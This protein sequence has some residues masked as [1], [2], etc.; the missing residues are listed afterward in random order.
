MNSL[1]RINQFAWWA[2]GI[3][4]LSLILLA[5]AL[6]GCGPAKQDAKG[7]GKDGAPVF[8][9]PARPVQTS[10]AQM[11]GLERTIAAVG[12]LAAYEQATLGVKVSGRMQLVSVDIGSPVKKGQLIAQL[13]KREYEVKLMQAE[14]LLAQ[15]RAKL[16]LPLGGDDD[17]V[18]A[19]Q[20]SIV[21]EAA[22]VLEEA[23]K[24]RE[25]VL[26]LSK[27]GVSSQ[28]ELETV[29][30]AYEVA[31]NRQRDA[32]EEVRNRQALLAQRR[33]EV[34]IAKQQLEETTIKAPFDGLVQDRRASQGEYLSVGAP[35]ATVV[36][37]DILRLRLDIPERRASLVKEGHP[38]RLTVTGD[39]NLYLGEIKR[40]SP[41]LSDLN[42]MLLVEA[43]VPNPGRLRPG[44]FAQADI[45]VSK[46]EP[47]LTVPLDALVTFAG[48]EKVVTIKEG[49]AQERPV[50]SG[51]RGANW[52]EILTGLK[53]GE[54]VVRNP[55][56]LRT[57]EPV[58]V[59]AGKES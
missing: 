11:Q 18:E 55:G 34:A 20:T 30:A 38:V 12:A 6:T 13:E 57:G 36:R 9:G 7:K 17:T 48:V 47:A 21:R 49:K 16:G 35:V 26:K 10:K 33:A 8:T 56:N 3:T 14:A 52:V 54:A 58:V 28:S 5:V 44:F 41:M 42:R 32:M 43:D 40:L 22:A 59:K 39:T 51:R 50:S 31:V 15:A 29:E 25:R 2:A 23:K 24:S 27:E 37:S 4:R 45:V 46:D 19:T 1:N 53:P